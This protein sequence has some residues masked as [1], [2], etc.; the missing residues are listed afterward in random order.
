MWPRKLNKLPPPFLQT[1]GSPENFQSRRRAENEI[2]S[3][4]GF[5]PAPGTF[6][7]D[8]GTHDLV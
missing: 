5:S 6:I 2:A 4:F 3:I 7:E 1:L 8:G